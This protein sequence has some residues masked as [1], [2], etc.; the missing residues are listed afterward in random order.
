M[1]NSTAYF[2]GVGTVFSAAALGF[3]GALLITTTTTPQLQATRLERH[4]ADS[5]QPAPV[6]ETKAT[7][8]ADAA[9]VS[10]PTA[11]QTAPTGPPPQQQTEQSG[12]SSLPP[13]ALTSPQTDLQAASSQSTQTVAEPQL[14]HP[15]NAF[16]RASG[17]EIK[18]HIRKRER[19]WARRHSH[20]QDNAQATASGDANSL[21]QQA[22]PSSNTSPPATQPSTLSSAQGLSQ[23]AEQQA[24][25]DTGGAKSDDA[26]SA[27]PVRKRNRRFA[28]QRYRDI[29]GDMPKVEVRNNAPYA[30]REVQR[31]DAPLFFQ[32]PHWR[33]SFR[34][35]DDD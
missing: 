25:S 23:P 13:A 8:N 6:H 28:R 27:R 4:L 5:A 18:K 12:S 34:E 20:D 32:A 19:F 35:D 31:E 16:A 21:A 1:R 7:V 9:Q 17:E 22:V 2:A 24:R 30:D 11:S 15:E 26:S 33:P 10:N 14:V 3:V 29:D